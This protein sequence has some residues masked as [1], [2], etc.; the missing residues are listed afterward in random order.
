MSFARI[1][2][3]AAVIISSVSLIALLTTNGP[4]AVII[5]KG[6][7]AIVIALFGIVLATRYPD[8]FH[9]GVRKGSYLKRGH[10][11]RYDVDYPPGASKRRA[12][13]S[14]IASAVIGVVLI[15]TGSLIG[16]T[17]L[18]SVVSGAVFLASTLLIAR[19]PILKLVLIDRVFSSIA[20]A[21]V[22]GIIL[23]AIVGPVGLAVSVIGAQTIVNVILLHPTLAMMSDAAREA[24][25]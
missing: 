25:R 9:A 11:E 8:A 12:I 18:I 15:V 19:G 24:D 13:V 22:P 23:A 17:V 10:T 6:F 16:A 21:L 20:L 2:S 5:G 3:I 4:G 7:E 1:G 14:A